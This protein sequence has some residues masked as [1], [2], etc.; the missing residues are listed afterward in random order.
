MI[1]GYT[2]ETDVGLSVPI[3]LPA[4]NAGIYVLD[5]HL[6]PVPTGVIGEMYVAGDGLARG[7]LNRPQLTA[8]KFLTAADPRREGP[9]ALSSVLRPTALRLYKTGDIARW[10]A[11]GRMEFLG[12]AD[13]QVKV[14]C[15]R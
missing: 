11:D 9:A 10:S 13:H 3:G 5:E 15:A 8:Q 7:Y 12:R 1:H 6:S 14:G 2:R 4:A